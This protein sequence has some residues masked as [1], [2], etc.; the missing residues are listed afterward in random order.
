MSPY[1]RNLWLA[2]VLFSLPST[3]EGK[4]F[5]FPVPEGFVVME[6][7]AGAPPMSRI[8]DSFFLEAKSYETYAVHVGPDGVDATCLTKIFPG[9]VPLSNLPGFARDS[10]ESSS[11]QDAQILSTRVVDV[12]GVRSG[13]IELELHRDGVEWRL[14][15][16]LLSGRDHWAV[17]RLAAH[18][19]EYDDASRRVEAIVP[20]IQGLAAPEKTNIGGV[21]TAADEAQHKLGLL[22]AGGGLGYVLNKLLRRRRPPQPRA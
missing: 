8:D 17:L 10:L 9:N 13:R 16:Y 20:N 19:T 12:A 5:T 7:G 14:L 3:A 6:P 1:A 18:A 11:L 4:P 15:V 2:L 21:V 22:F